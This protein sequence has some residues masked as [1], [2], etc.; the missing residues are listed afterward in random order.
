VTAAVPARRRRPLRLL[1]RLLLLL[2]L[3]YGV[4]VLIG[5]PPALPFDL[6]INLAPVEIDDTLRAPA[7]GKRRL[8][9]LQHGLW[10]SSWSLWRLERA[11]VA[12]GYLVLN[13]GYPSTQAKVEDHAERLHAAL[14]AEL[15]AIG[16]V[17]EIMFVGHSLGG[18]V[19]A[20]YLRRKD[21]CKPAQCVYIASPL[22][23]AM[24][25]ELRKRWWLFGLLMGDQAALQLC[26]DSALA[27]RRV[28]MPC[29]CGTIVGDLGDGNAAIPGRDDGTIGVG[30][31]H[32]AGEVDS[33]TLPLGHTAISC[34]EATIRQV[35]HFLRHGKFATL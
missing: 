20:E 11:L 10:R 15:A 5:L 6:A 30:E 35:L 31:A 25:C 22:H 23:G 1:C 32:L 9:V 34:S 29:P 24:L 14:T 13:R 7:D 21:A 27:Q 28:P 33:V 18:L 19:I 12:Q 3:G 17:D 26:P 8:V 2:L 16:P 4:A